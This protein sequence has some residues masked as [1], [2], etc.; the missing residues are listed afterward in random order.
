M[1]CAM[2]MNASAAEPRE[3]DVIVVG[4]GAGGMTAALCCQSQGLSALVIE[5]QAR[6][7]GTSAVS[8]GGIWIPCNDDI[9]SCGGTDSP[10]EALGYLKTLTRG[11]VPLPRLEAYVR[12]AVGM[13]RFMA[14]RFGIRFRAVKKY[15]DYFPEHG[16][17]PGYRTMEPFD[18]DAAKLGEELQRLPLQFPTTLLMGRISMDQVEA[19]VLFTRGPGWIGLMLRMVLRYWLDLPWRLRSPRD[20]RQV[21]GQALVASLR[22]AM[23][24]RK[25]PLWLETGM[26]SLAWEN[27]RVA[28]VNVERKGERFR[29]TARRG[30]ILAAGGFEANQQM[31]EQYLPQPTSAAWSAAPPINHGDAIR[32]GQALGAA[33]AFMDLT[34]GSPTVAVSSD[35][36]AC[37]IFVERALPGSVVVNKAGRRFVN[38][39]CPYTEFVYAMHAEQARSGGGVPCWLVFDATFRHKYPM[40]PL[41]PGQIQPDK[42]LPKDWLDR[43]YYRADT[44]EALAAR[45]GVDAAGLAET[46]RVFNGNAARGEDPQFNRGGN[47]FER[48]YSDPSVKPNPCLG[49]LLKAP[50]YAARLDAGELGTKGGLLADE[51]ARVLREDGSVIPGLYAIGNC[52]AAVMGR[53][54]PGPGATLGPAMTFAYIAAHEIAKTAGVGTQQAGV[55]Q[56]A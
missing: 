12:N 53:T 35:R 21:L 36:P 22:H 7:G 19:H 45:I 18:F 42:A 15:P 23:L 41:L 6:Y 28:G 44:L 3:Y 51:A 55:A 2:G 4:S 39:A 32:A 5:K 49:P 11:E 10:E 37:G 46:V 34:W 54:Y 14:Q 52:S 29:L 1:V 25:L 31:R 33:T 17:K 43:V 47:V 48:Y 24:E 16:G 8:G 20:R 50:F 30:V 56:A 27:G 13:V 38:E 40:G 26:E 9:P